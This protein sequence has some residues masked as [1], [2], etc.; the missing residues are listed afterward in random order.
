MAKSRGE[1]TKKTKRTVPGK[2]IKRAAKTNK[3]DRKAAEY[4]NSL[5]KLHKLQAVLLNKLNKEI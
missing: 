4:V 2:K 3:C 1:K 5:L